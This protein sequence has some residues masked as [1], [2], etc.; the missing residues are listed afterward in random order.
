[1]LISC[2]SVCA[3]P[4]RDARIEQAKAVFQKCVKRGSAA[5]PL[6]Q[7][8]HGGAFLQHGSR[9]RWKRRQN[10]RCQKGEC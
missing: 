8:F 4:N 1:M 3:D 2:V 6:D 10:A 5:A 7:V 9:P